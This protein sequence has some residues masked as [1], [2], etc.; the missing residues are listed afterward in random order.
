MVKEQKEITWETP[1]ET[2]LDETQKPADYKIDGQITPPSINIEPYI[3]KRVKIEQI[4]KRIGEDNFK[5]G[6]KTHYVILRTTPVGVIEG[7]EG[8]K[9]E[10]R[11]SRILNLKQNELTG[12]IGWIEGDKTDLFLKSKKVKQ[13]EELIGIEVVVIPTQPRKDGRQFLTF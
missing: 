13:L 2:N 6:K 10:L 4:E 12:E 3:G 9:I 5:P 11:P 1:Q 8:R 7:K